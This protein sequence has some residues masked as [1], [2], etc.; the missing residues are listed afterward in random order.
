MAEEMKV[1][2]VILEG[3]DMRLE[4]LAKAHLARLAEVGLD[5]EL[6]RWIPVPV[7]TVGELAVYI[8]TGLKEQ[9]RGSRCGSR[10]WNRPMGVLRDLRTS[11][12]YAT[13]DLLTGAPLQSTRVR[14]IWLWRMA[15]TVSPTRQIVE[16]AS[17]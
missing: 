13:P 5:E 16:E 11:T 15:W 6:W 14:F 2:P 17:A 7:R 9:E 4:P 3:R 1:V 8:E 10:S 12:F